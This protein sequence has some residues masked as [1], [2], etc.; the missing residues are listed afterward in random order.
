MGQWGGGEKA[1]MKAFILLG[2]QGILAAQQ[3]LSANGEKK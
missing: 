2:T 1:L 3:K